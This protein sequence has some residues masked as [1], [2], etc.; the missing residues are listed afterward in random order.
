MLRRIASLSLLCAWLCASGAMLDVAQGV[1]WVRMFAGY[2]G[3]ESVAAAA[4][5]TFDPAKPCA[6]CRAVSKARDAAC[7]NCPAAPVAGAE[8]MVMIVQASETLVT[9]AEEAIWPVPARV[10][11]PV[12]T[13]EVVLPPPK[14]SLAS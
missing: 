6:L 10:R 5:D 13:S 1:A 9:E 14:T 12:R 7:Q 11:G 2:V 4:S 3:T 8:K